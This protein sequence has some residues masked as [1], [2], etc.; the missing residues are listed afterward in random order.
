MGQFKGTIL[1]PRKNILIENN[2]T[3]SSSP[4]NT[5]AGAGGYKRPRSGSSPGSLDRN[6]LR[7]QN[8]GQPG[9]KTSNNYTGHT[10]ETVLN[11]I[12]QGVDEIN[13]YNG[14]NLDNYKNCVTKA[15]LNIQKYV[16]VLAFRIGQVEMENLNLRSIQQQIR[17]M[18]LT[19]PPQDHIA[20][21]LSY[22]AITQSISRTPASHMANPGN[23]EW[24]TS[25]QQKRHETIVKIKDQTDSKIVLQEIKKKC[26]RIHSMWSF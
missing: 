13:T 23:S 12:L 19:Q 17:N 1:T 9:D 8:T 25:P 20:P 24:K 5:D 2:I 14:N 21:K 15:L 16:T 18:Q 11:L 3:Q 4:I 26:T 22:S 10:T 6:K 7:K